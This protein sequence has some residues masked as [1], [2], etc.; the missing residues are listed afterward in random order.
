MKYKT[1][2]FKGSKRKL[3]PAITKLTLEVEDVETFYD[4]F[5]GSGIVSAH[6]RHNGLEVFSSDKSPSAALYAGVF[7][8]GFDKDLVE[9]EIK[10]INNLTGK[11]GWIFKNYSGNFLR[12]VRGEASPQWRP[13]AFS[14]SN[15]QKLDAIFDYIHSLQPSAEKNAL[16]FSAIIAMNKVFNGTNDQKSSL[17]E[18][19]SSS[20]K[21][22]RLE[23]PT[24]IEGIR[25]TV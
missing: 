5:S 4:G 10:K 23:V 7:L 12:P 20:K 25:G 1:T 21:D 18:W 8:N 9:K 24:L 16:L 6:M 14:V 11:K 13:R 3:L 15:G 17:K 22:V 2:G 19:S